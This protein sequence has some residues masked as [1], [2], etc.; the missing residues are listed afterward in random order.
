MA[1]FD[2][3]YL[4]H[5]SFNP[6][7]LVGNW[8]E[9]R[10]DRMVDKKAIVPGVYGHSECPAEHSLYDETYQ[11]PVMEKQS[12]QEFKRQAFVN[13]LNSNETHFRTKDSDEFLNNMIT[14]SDIMYN[15]RPAKARAETASGQKLIEKNEDLLGTYSHTTETGIQR[16]KLQHDRLGEHARRYQTT[17]SNDF[18]QRRSC[19]RE[20]T[21]RERC[22]KCKK[23]PLFTT[24]E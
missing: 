4:N 2:F 22:Q 20:K 11:R 14:T 13:R 21:L 15:I 1:L 10:C 3:D 19:P 17:Y 8:F 16:S 7:V 23:P 12:F 24:D 18:Q 9:E 6:N 5:K